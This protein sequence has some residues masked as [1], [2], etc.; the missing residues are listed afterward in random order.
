MSLETQRRF[1][2]SEWR[3]VMV[4][5]TSYPIMYKI[6]RPLRSNEASQSFGTNY[7]A[8]KIPLGNRIITKWQEQ[9]RP[10]DN[11]N[12]QNES[13][14]PWS[15]NYNKVTSDNNQ[16]TTTT[17]VTDHTQIHQVLAGVGLDPN[18]Y[19]ISPSPEEQSSRE[20][21]SNKTSA[22]TTYPSPPEQ[23]AQHPLTSQSHSLFTSARPLAYVEQPPPQP[24]PAQLFPGYPSTQSNNNQ[25]PINQQ[26]GPPPPPT[27][28]S[29][30]SSLS[31]LFNQPSSNTQNTISQNT[32]SQNIPTQNTTTQ[33]SN[34]MSHYCVSPRR[35]PPPPPSHCHPHHHHHHH[36]QHRDSSLSAEHY[37]HQVN[38][39]CNP[40]V[41]VVKPSTQNV[42]YKKEI[43]IRYLQPPTPPPPAPIIIREKHIPPDPP[44]SPLLI[45]ERKPEARTPPPLTIRERPPTPP[46]P[47]EPYIIEKKLPPPPPHP[48]QIII[49]RLPTPP[50]KPRTVIFEK[51][52]PYKK[53]KRP[54]LLQR[55]P[56]PEPIKPA[57][58]V[59]IE[60]EPLKAYTVR[61]VIE[62]GVFRVDPCQFSSYN[63]KTQN[64][65]GDVRIVERIE[66]LPPPSEQLRRVL[67]EYSCEHRCSPSHISRHDYHSH[68]NLSEHI[69]SSIQ[70]LLTG[71]RP[72]SNI[73]Q[74]TNVSRS[75]STPAHRHDRVLSTGSNSS[76]PSPTHARLPSSHSKTSN[77][78]V[79][80]RSPPHGSPMRYHEDDIY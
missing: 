53:L 21:A 46:K 23:N 56:T 48:R 2:L 30:A 60:Y 10:I 43:R 63:A 71:A 42:V 3:I 20:S 62:E 49:E 80:Q 39:H 4:S 15:R 13:N 50:P 28:Q 32:T 36:H 19:I 51:W 61:R 59:V 29:A 52:L 44:Q 68:Q 34:D 18:D 40:P 55:A 9:V 38:S 75:S 16:E 26:Q 5:Q 25:P 47:L 70:H 54:V 58:N 22:F 33:P 8:V 74:L 57:R 11:E 67:N 6:D 65:G 76:V 24:P 7:A 78:I 77:R 73:D 41:K 14:N 17:R 69:P 72:T 37:I 66:D 27:S 12:E 64:C 45:R 35:S 1:I 31:F 79:E